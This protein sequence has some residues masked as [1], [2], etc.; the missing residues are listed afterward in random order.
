VAIRHSDARK[1]L[2]ELAETAPER[3]LQT[4]VVDVVDAIERAMVAGGLTR[5]EVARR[6]G[7]KREYVSRILNNPSNVTVAT[8]VR[9]ANAVSCELCIDL[10]PRIG[11]YASCVP[12]D[13]AHQEETWS[14]DEDY[15]PLALTA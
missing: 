7:L 13:S 6:A 11:S 10:M 8:L 1:W 3:G 15:E 14:H 12:V 4:L 9:L 5:T 2:D